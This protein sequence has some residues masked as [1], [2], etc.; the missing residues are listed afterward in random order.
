MRQYSK[1]CCWIYI[2][3][4]NNMKTHTQ[5]GFTLF[6]ALVVMSAILLGSMAVADSV[7]KQLRLSSNHKE[8]SKAFAAAN[9]G[10]ECALYYDLPRFD[11]FNKDVLGNVSCGQNKSAS[12]SRSVINATTDVFS[13]SLDFE[14]GSS[15]GVTVTKEVTFDSEGDVVSTDTTIESRGY[16][17]SDASA[18]RIERAVRASYTL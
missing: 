5:S 11:Y 12:V 15:A 13:F 6:I 10:I 17:T 2:V 8:S 3:I 18:R 14:Q 1:V 9:N 4:M 7:W 16:N